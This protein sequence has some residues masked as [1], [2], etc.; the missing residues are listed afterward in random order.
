MHNVAPSRA[1]ARRSRQLLALAL[2]IGA[3]G[4]FIVALGI[5]MIMI[6]LVAEGSGSFTIYNLLRDGLVVFGAL[7]FLVALGV[8]IRAATWRTDNDLA[9]EVGRYLGKTLDAR[10]TLI[11]NVSRRDLGYVDAIL[12]GPPGVLVF[13]L[14]PDKGVF[15][16]EG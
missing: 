14:I 4:A 5:L 10:Y 16:N 2:V 7:L 9:H 11:R 8:A 3:L 13:R 12:V 15:A 6:P 1:L